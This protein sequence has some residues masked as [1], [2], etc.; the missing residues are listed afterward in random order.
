MAQGPHA[1]LIGPVG[2]SS[3]L[4]VMGNVG[5]GIGAAVRG[6]IGASVATGSEV[7]TGAAVTGR[8][9]PFGTMITS[10]QLKNC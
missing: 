2:V 3:R 9:S 10:A 7:E 8:D 1:G 4:L 6:G 5:T